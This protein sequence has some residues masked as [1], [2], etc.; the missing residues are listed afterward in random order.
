MHTGSDWCRKYIKLWTHKRHPQL[1]ITAKL[2]CI[3]CEYFVEDQLF[4]MPPHC[5]SERHFVGLDLHLVLLNM[6]N[7]TLP[8]HCTNNWHLVTIGVHLFGWYASNLPGKR[9]Q[10]FWDHKK[11]LVLIIDGVPGGNSDIPIIQRFLVLTISPLRGEYSN[12]S[13]ISFTGNQ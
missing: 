13:W 1:E 5:S 4:I 11:E 9:P 2:W 7:V 12:H 8:L 6:D 3:Y 10:F